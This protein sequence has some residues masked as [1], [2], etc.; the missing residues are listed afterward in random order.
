MSQVRWT[1][2]ESKQ[3]IDRWKESGMDKSSFCKEQ[4]IAYGRFL[5]WCKRIGV[6]AHETPVTDGLVRLEVVADKAAGKL[7]I[8]GPNG[9]ILHMDANESS[10]S[11]IKALLTA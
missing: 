8:T 10:V 11:F 6:S 2:S 4:G 9:L 7:S 1:E 5:Y 3:L